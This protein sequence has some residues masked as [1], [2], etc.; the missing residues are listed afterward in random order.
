M[1]QLIRSR[2]RFLPRVDRRRDH[3]ANPDVAAELVA[4]AEHR[5]ALANT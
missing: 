2:R 4:I 3:T 5:L 1:K